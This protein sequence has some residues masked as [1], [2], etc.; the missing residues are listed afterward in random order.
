[1]PFS[2]KPSFETCMMSQN[3]L[4]VGIGSWVVVG[5]LIGSWYGCGLAAQNHQ[6]FLPLME[7]SFI[8]AHAVGSEASW[9]E[10]CDCHRDVLVACLTARKK[11]KLLR[12]MRTNRMDGLISCLVKYR[13]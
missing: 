9:M 10:G 13:K 6:K 8:H 4:V 3:F 2:R 12:E 11:V 1:M 5:S 7:T